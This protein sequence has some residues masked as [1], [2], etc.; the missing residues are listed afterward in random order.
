MTDKRLRSRLGR[1]RRRRQVLPRPAAVL[2]ARTTRHRGQHRR[3]F[4]APRPAYLAGRRLGSYTRWPTCNDPGARLGSRGRDLEFHGGDGAPRRRN[5]VQARRSRSGDAYPADRSAGGRSD[6]VGGYLDA[7]ATP[8]HHACGR[9]DE[10]RPP[11]AALSRPTKASSIS[12]IISC[13]GNASR[14]FAACGFEGAA[15][16]ATSAGFREALERAEAIVITPSNPFVS[17]DPILALPGINDA[18]S[19]AAGGRSLADRR[20]QGGER[21]RSAR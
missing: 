11:S 3:R 2:A 5:L 16:A 17:I 14:H 18:L 12:R 1:R 20:R 15:D 10:R 19:A 6:A 8:R 13:G 9:A 7:C 4:R 21:A